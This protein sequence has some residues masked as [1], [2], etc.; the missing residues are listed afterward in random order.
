[1]PRQIIIGS[2]YTQAYGAPAHAY[3][4]P[5]KAYGELNIAGSVRKLRKSSIRIYSYY[6]NA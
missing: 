3:E 4:G 1:M 6:Y 2:F 5:A